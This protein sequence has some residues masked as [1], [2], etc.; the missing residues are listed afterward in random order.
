MEN[1]F[2]PLHLIS[3][4]YVAWNVFHADHSGFNWM[5][6]KEKLLSKKEVSKYHHG[7]WIG[8]I[9]MVI[10]G[11][12]LFYPMREFLLTRPQFYVK[13]SFVLVLIINGLA[14]GK[15]SHIATEKTFDSLTAQEKFP[16]LLSG[17]IS[18]IAWLGALITAFFLIPD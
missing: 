17:A 16:L 8:L 2:L 5:R 7:T 10:T 3:L 15:I 1:V 12:S 6:G 11:A 9:L 13:M 4:A 18:T 14:I